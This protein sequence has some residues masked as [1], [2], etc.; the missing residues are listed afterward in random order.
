VDPLTILL[1]EDN[2]AQAD[3]IQEMLTEA[4]D[5]QFELLWVRRLD[6]S[7]PYLRETKLDIVLLDLSLP[8][9]Y[10]LDTIRQIKFQSTTT[11][12][13]VLT[14][15][16]DRTLAIESVRQ[17]AQDYLV[18]GEFSG[19]LLV[20]AIN[21]AIE[22]QRIKE[23]LQQQIEREQLMGRMIERIRQSLELR[24]ILQTTVAEVR[25]FLKID[26]VL[27]YRCPNQDRGIIVAESVRAVSQQG[28]NASREVLQILQ[29]P[30][31]DDLESNALEV[32]IDSLVNAVLTV[33]IW[34]NPPIPNGQ[35]QLWGQLIVHGS[36]GRQWQQWEIDFLAQLA[37]QVAIAIQQSE[38]YQAVEQR[39]ILDGLTG[40]ANRRQFDHVL[41]QEWQRL[42]RE[43]RPLSL[44]LCDVDF[45]HDYNRTYGLLAGD[46][47]LQ[48]IAQTIQQASQR[49]ADL[50][51]RYGGEEF[52]VILPNTNAAGAF[53]VA[54]KIRHQL[55]ANELPYLESS[56]SDYVTLSFGVATHIPSA[57]QAPTILID[58]ADRLLRQAKLR[59]RNQIVQE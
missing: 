33:P 55:E 21:Y 46:T 28:E 39:A 26:R 34:Q 50:V 32:I 14:N 9:S 57:D 54:Q 37:N 10:G 35:N 53:A 40:I 48:Q 43:S 23:E 6:D 12:I 45:F 27:I 3:L 1:I 2:L 19:E 15:L 7:L 31:F 42:A 41:A 44:I 49:P 58:M 25:Q 5:A 51:A 20:R 4:Q 8:D 22:R 24:E 16:N 56:V 11:P 29:T 47:C 30:Q 13:V 59:G 38:L 18:K 52:A 17:G 36:G